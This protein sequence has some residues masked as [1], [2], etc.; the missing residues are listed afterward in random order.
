VITKAW[1][2]RTKA[3]PRFAFFAFKLKKGSIE[4]A[5]NLAENQRN[6]AFSQITR[7]W[8][9]LWLFEPLKSILVVPQHNLKLCKLLSP[10][11]LCST[12]EADTWEA[13]I[14]DDSALQEWL[15]EKI[16]GWEEA[17]ADPASV[18]PNFPQ[19]PIQA[20]RSLYSKNKSLSKE[21]RKGIDLFAGVESALPKPSFRLY[22]R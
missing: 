7:D 6:V 16:K 11:Q 4:L 9:K 22:L 1:S 15:R 14:G 18:A 3:I 20:S 19:T 8:P 17:V 5:A 2:S 10:F 21:S 12:T 13:F